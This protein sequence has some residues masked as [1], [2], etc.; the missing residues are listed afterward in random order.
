MDAKN[1]IRIAI[2]LFI[3]VLIL[4]A[5]SGWIWAG[6][7]QPAAQSAA[8]RVVLTLCIV[9]GL[10]GLTALWRTRSPK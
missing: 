8:S 7:H 1:I 10:T 9:A 6:S 2:S 4:V 5:S 3:V